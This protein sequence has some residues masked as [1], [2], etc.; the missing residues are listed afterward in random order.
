MLYSLQ[1]HSKVS[2]YLMDAVIEF[3]SV[4]L[5]VNTNSRPYLGDS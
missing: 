2:K 3:N 1:L 5:Q 4:D